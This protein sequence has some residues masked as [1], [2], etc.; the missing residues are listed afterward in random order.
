MLDWILNI[1]LKDPL[2]TMIIEREAWL[3]KFEAVFEYKN[4]LCQGSKIFILSMDLVAI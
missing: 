4:W 3:F 1:L 2:L